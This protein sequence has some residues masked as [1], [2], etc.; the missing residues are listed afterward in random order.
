MKINDLAQ[1][2]IAGRT[3]KD[4]RTFTFLDRGKELGALPE[5]VGVVCNRLNKVCKKHRTDNEDEVI[6]RI[7][8]S[9]VGVWL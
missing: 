8:I 1:L 9:G 7:N 2:N 4:V 3:I 5:E 6:Q